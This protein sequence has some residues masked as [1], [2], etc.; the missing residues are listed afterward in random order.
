MKKRLVLLILAFTGGY[1]IR[2][3]TVPPSFLTSN[4]IV[5]SVTGIKETA[6][7]SPLLSK[8]EYKNGT[9]VPDALSIHKG[10]YLQIVNAS[11]NDLMW[12][13]STEPKLRTRR[14]YRYLEQLK[15]RLDTPGDITV[16]NKLN[17]RAKLTIV[18][19]E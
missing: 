2:H 4:R 11:E 3:Y 17:L 1:L 7:I 15:T 18:V 8:I 19:S 10:N 13:E 6:D 16:T 9:F 12:L 5:E 14:G